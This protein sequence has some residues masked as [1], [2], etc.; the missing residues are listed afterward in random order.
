MADDRFQETA[1]TLIAEFGEEAEQ[2]AVLRA[3]QCGLRADSAGE[4]LWG[5]VREAVVA[6]LRGAET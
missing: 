2:V 1:K 5:R 3:E 6:I 4:K